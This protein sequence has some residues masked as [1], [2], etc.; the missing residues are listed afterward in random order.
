MNVNRPAV[1]LEESGQAVDDGRGR[2]GDDVGVGALY[3]AQP[4]G[5]QRST[6]GDVPVDRQQHRQPGVHHP[7]HVG[8]REQ[9]AV[10]T[11]QGLG[12]VDVD[13]RRHVAER[14]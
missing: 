13:E 4:L 8:A 7:Q 14:A 1:V 9:P 11:Q 3:G 2:D 12:V 6:H 10:E 5:V